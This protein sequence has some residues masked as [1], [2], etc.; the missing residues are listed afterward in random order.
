MSDT[1]FGRLWALDLGDD[2][3]V[4][5]GPLPEIMPGRAIATLPGFQWVDS[6]KV[7][8]DGGV[9]VGTLFAQGITVVRPDGH[10]E[11]VAV[12]NELFVTNLCFAGDDMQDV[13]VTASST[14][15]ILKTRWPRPG[16][17]L[18]FNA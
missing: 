4:K 3:T 9:C 18:A 14:G 11:F 12:P 17:K 2:N 15:R 6:L 1:L 7:E 16:L 5:P 8:A 10:A 13:F